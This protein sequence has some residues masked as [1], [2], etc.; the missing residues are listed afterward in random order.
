MPRSI[1][2]TEFAQEHVETA[3]ELFQSGGAKSC[4][5]TLA[6][7]AEEVLGNLISRKKEKNMMAHLVRL[8]KERHLQMSPSDVYN[9]VNKTRN[10]LKH[11]NDPTEDSIEFDPEE[12]TAMVTRAM[13]NF[14]MLTGTLT[15]KMESFLENYLRKTWLPSNPA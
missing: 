2:K 12:A 8:A 6:A 9:L 1:H 14:Q 4:V 11:A 5:L 10:A 3:I 13:A 7:A 15:P